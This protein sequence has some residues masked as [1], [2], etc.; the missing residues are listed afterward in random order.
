M[1]QKTKGIVLHR[2]KYGDN[3]L[4]V[5]LY[6]EEFGRLSFMVQG[7]R[8]KK[9]RSRIALLQ[10]FFLIDA[11]IYYHE[12]KGLQRMKEFAPDYG[13]VSI[14]YHDVKRTI[15]LFL[16][17]I[18]YKVL[19]EEETN[20][21]LFQFI[22]ESIVAF[23]LMDKGLAYFHLVFLIELTKHLGFYPQD[24]YSNA[25]EYFDLRKGSF[26]TIKPDGKDYLP[27]GLSSAF[28]ELMKSGFKNIGDLN[29]SRNDRQTLLDKI[30]DYYHLHFE[31]K[32]KI[33][34]LDVMRQIFK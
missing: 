25:S 17:E 30:L 20:L 27:P 19:R 15:V 6:T 1:L 29:F 24:N 13:F 32:G 14:P 11:V 4:V 7:I 12:R 34:S 2:I 33:S 18:L 22:R 26:K 21:P 28:S 9:A 23:D 8:S 5:Y 3:G 10:P 31:L 16:A